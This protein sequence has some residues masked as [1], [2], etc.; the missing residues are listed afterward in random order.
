[1]RR[2][3]PRRELLEGVLLVCLLGLQHAQ[4]LIHVDRGWIDGIAL[5]PRRLPSEIAAEIDEPLV[6]DEAREPH[7]KQSGLLD[8]RVAPQIAPV[9]QG[10]DHPGVVASIASVDMLDE[11][12]ERLL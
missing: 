3:E 6:L 1:M 9:D 7:P 11:S 10:R 2:A 8:E 5:E 4:P 12:V